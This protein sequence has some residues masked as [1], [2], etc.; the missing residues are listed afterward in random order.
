VAEKNTPMASKHWIAH[1]YDALLLYTVTEQDTAT[2][3]KILRSVYE[4]HKDTAPF[5]A[6][7]HHF[8]GELNG[9]NPDHIG[10]VHEPI[11]TDGGASFSHR[12]E[13]LGRIIDQLP[14]V[15]DLPLE[16]T[17]TPEKFSV[18]SLAAAIN[19]ARPFLCSR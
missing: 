8:Q 4:E 17:L 10:W 12:L 18:D 6:T 5:Y 9:V 3:G 16:A 14:R 11:P 15:T 2:V 19:P 1:V 7:P 13:H